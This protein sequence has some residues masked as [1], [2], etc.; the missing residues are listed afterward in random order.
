MIARGI[1]RINM[2]E[3]RKKNTSYKT[4]KKNGNIS[5]SPLTKSTEKTFR[6]I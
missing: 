2:I 4:E 3:K 6:F 5:L 1:F